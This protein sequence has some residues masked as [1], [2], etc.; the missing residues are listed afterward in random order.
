MRGRRCACMNSRMG[1]PPKPTDLA[2]LQGNPGRRAIPDDQPVPPKGEI[3]PP[4]RLKGAARDYFIATATMLAAFR[5][6]L[7]YPAD[8]QVIARYCE[9]LVRYERLVA[10]EDEAE[11][12]KARGSA[13]GLVYAM[14]G[15]D[16]KRVT[17]FAEMPQAKMIDRLAD[18]L[19]ELERELGMTPKARSMMRVRAVQKQLP[20]A[21]QDKPK[22]SHWERSPSVVAK[23]G[24][25]GA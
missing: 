8:T 16:S 14:R 15:K 24:G 21:V 19:I 22:P 23:I 12:K 5:P 11:T 25:V 6:S 1:R 13:P 10:W 4:A 9:T 7:A 18:R 2:K 20:D 3:V 17:A